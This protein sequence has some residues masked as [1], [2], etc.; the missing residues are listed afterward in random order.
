[1]N[2]HQIGNNFLMQDVN[3]NKQVSHDTCLYYKINRVDDHQHRERGRE[4]ILHL[5]HREYQ[6][7]Q[8]QN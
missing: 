7:L 3:T 6:Q 1:M 5:S 4:P 8:L 2:D